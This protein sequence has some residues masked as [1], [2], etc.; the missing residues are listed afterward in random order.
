VPLPRVLEGIAR[1][2]RAVSEV[3]TGR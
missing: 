3:M 1:L 2:K